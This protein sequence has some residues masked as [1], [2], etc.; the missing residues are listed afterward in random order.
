MNLTFNYLADFNE[1]VDQ[2]LNGEATNPLKS[3]LYNYKND[4]EKSRSAEDESENW[5]RQWLPMQS[6]DEMIPPKVLPK[7]KEQYEDQAITEF[8]SVKHWTGRW[9][10][11][12]PDDSTP[13]PKIF[14]HKPNL[15]HEYVPEIPHEISMGH[16]SPECDDAKVNVLSI[17][18][19]ILFRKNI[20]FQQNVCRMFLNCDNFSDQPDY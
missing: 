4:K 11:E 10:P 13:P 3:L 9:M 1:N 20:L 2:E 19:Y 8:P 14:P 7:N 12:R 18:I 15:A 5:L 17:H 16:V 6:N